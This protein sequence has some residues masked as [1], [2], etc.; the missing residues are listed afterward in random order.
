MRVCRGSL[1][2]CSKLFS[3]KSSIV[4]VRLRWTMGILK[5]GG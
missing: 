3:K 2:L 4:N 1:K 5:A